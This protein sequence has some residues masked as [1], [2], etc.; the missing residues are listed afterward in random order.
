MSSMMALGIALKDV[1]PTL[2][3]H[4]A[5]MLGLAD[6][7]GALTPGHAAD[8][9]VLWDATAAASSC[10]TTGTPRS[11]PSGCCVRHFACAGKRFDAD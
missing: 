2:T 9:S 6:R 4:P 1:V 7:L 8:V 5:Q 10:A 3:T 11:S